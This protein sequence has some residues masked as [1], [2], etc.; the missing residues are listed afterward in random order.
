MHVRFADDD[1]ACV[2]QLLD[3]RSVL[4]RNAVLERL[5]RRRRLHPGGVVEVFDANRDAVKRTAPVSRLN[6]RFGVPRLFTRGVR[7]HGDERI[8][9]RCELFDARQHGIDHIDR[10]DFPR[11]HSLR[12]R[13]DAEVRNRFHIDKFAAYWSRLTCGCAP[14]AR[15]GWPLWAASWRWPPLWSRRLQTA[16]TRRFVPRKPPRS[17]SRP[18]FSRHTASPV[19]TPR[20]RP[21]GSRSTA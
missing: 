2:L 10:R 16:A 20:S 7:E 13:G 1:C 18:T 17:P 15:V 4:L 12:D 19:T 5:E 9:S 3:G 11:S 6:L 21:Q 14:R 8:Q